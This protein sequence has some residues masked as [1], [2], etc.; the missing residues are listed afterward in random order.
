[1]DLKQPESQDSQ[2]PPKY[3]D[4]LRLQHLLPLRHLKNLNSSSNIGL[5]QWN[6]EWTKDGASSF[7]HWQLRMLSSQIWILDYSRNYELH[8]RPEKDFLALDITTPDAH[9]YD[10]DPDKGKLQK[11]DLTKKRPF[12]DLQSVELQHLRFKRPKSRMQCY[13]TT[14][15]TALPNN[16]SML[17]ACQQFYSNTMLEQYYTQIQIDTRDYRIKTIEAKMGNK[18]LLLR[19]LPAAGFTKPILLLP[20]QWETPCWPPLCMPMFLREHRQIHQV[21]PED[22]PRQ[23][24]DLPQGQF[25]YSS[26]R[27]VMHPMV[28]LSCII[29]PH[30]HSLHWWAI[31]STPPQQHWWWPCWSTTCSSTTPT[32][33]SQLHCGQAHQQRSEEPERSLHLFH[34]CSICSPLAIC[35]YFSK[36]P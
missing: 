18:V 15:A 30:C 12:T 34:W 31:P 3:H 33:H 29:S 32:E 23:L 11:I 9:H 36:A 27:G 24:A 35:S 7:Q 25:R 5:L 28:H 14:K 6:P 13:S 20:Y 10:P 4:L 8:L 16:R 2:E 26:C 21:Q 17:E 1:M 22:Y 19:R